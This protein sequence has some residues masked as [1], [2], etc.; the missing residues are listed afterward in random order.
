VRGDRT[1]IELTISDLPIHTHVRVMMEIMF[2]LPLEIVDAI[3]KVYYDK[4]SGYFFKTECGFFTSDDNNRIFNCDHIDPR[5]HTI[6]YLE[7]DNQ[8]EHPCD[9]LNLVLEFVAKWRDNIS[10]L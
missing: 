1:I 5:A 10:M 6:R 9:R 2:I 7:V 8:F 3:F 4:T